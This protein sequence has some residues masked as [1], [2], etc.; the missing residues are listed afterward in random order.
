MYPGAWTSWLETTT[1]TEIQ[2]LLTININI[3]HEWI[4]KEKLIMPEKYKWIS[5]NNVFMRLINDGIIKLSK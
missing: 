1:Y 2:I 5:N 4:K 3:N